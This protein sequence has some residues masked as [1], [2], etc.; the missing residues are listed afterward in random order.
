MTPAAPRINV[1]QA[2]PAWRVVDFISDLHLSPQAPGATRIFLDFLGGPARAAGHLFILGDLFDVWPGDDCL[3]AAPDGYPRTIVNAL[4]ALTV[5][6]VSLSL[7]LMF[8]VNPPIVM[9]HCVSATESFCPI[10]HGMVT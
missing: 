4:R 7:M 8:G 3:D 10:D 2:T 5:S 9:T 1:L 6:G